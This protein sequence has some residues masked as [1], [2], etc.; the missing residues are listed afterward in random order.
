MMDGYPGK[1]ERTVVATS[2]SLSTY[3]KAMREREV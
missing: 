2:L 3:V 1:M